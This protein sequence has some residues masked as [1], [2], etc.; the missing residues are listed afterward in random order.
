[1]LTNSYS[2]AFYPVNQLL[3]LVDRLV[4]VLRKNLVLLLALRQMEVEKVSLLQAFVKLTKIIHQLLRFRL[5]LHQDVICLDLVQYA[6]VQGVVDDFINLVRHLLDGVRDV[7]REE[8]H[9]VVDEE[10]G[11]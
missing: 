7:S 8:H 11:K 5:L 1:M 6:Q 3:N 2:E 9:A 10:V 4:R